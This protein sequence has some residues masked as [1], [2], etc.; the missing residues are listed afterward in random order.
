MVWIVRNRISSE[1][2]SRQEVASSR[3]RIAGSSKSDR[4]MASRYVAARKLA[5]PRPHALLETAVKGR[6]KF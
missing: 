6:N 5:C 4:A 1:T 2:T 3:I